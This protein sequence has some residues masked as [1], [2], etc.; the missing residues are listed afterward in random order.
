MES[1]QQYESSASDSDFHN[2]ELSTHQ[3]RQ[4]YLVT[5][6]QADTKQIPNEKIIRRGCSIILSRH[7]YICRLLVLFTG[8]A[9]A[10]WCPLPLSYKAYQEPTLVSGQKILTR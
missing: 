5:Y 4:V 3:V 10:F 9:W 7:D 2:D 8:K 6:S 1:L